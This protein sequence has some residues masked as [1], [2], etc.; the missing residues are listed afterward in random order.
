MVSSRAGVTLALFNWKKK[1]D[2]ASPATAATGER[3]GDAAPPSTAGGETGD[4]QPDPRRATKWFQHAASVA[5]TRNY[6][7]AVE[8]YVNGLKFDADNMSQHEALFEVAKRRKVN[9]GKP[10]GMFD[11]MKSMGKDAVSRFLDAERIWAKDPLNRDAMLPVLEKAAEVHN[12]IESLDLGR[13]IQWVGQMTLDANSKHK[14]PSKEAFVKAR[15]VFTAVGEYDLAVNA[16]KLALAMDESDDQLLLE[17]RDLEAERTMTQ[18][19]YGKDFKASVKDMD[20][21]RELDASDEI[22]RG[23]NAADQ[24][25]ARLR[26]EVEEAP[27]DLDKLGKLVKAME[28]RETDETDAQAIKLLRDAHERTG[29]YRFKLRAGDVTMRQ[30]NRRL[31]ALRAAFDA[32]HNN[33]EARKALADATHQ[34]RAFELEEFSERVKNYPT[35]LRLRFELGKRLYLTQKFDE[36]ISMFQEAQSDPKNKSGALFYLGACYQ[37]KGWHDEAVESF[38]RGIEAHP[39]SD[40]KLAMELRY[41]LMDALEQGA[42][43]DK[44]LD[45]AKEARD[46]G[47]QLLQTNINY[48]D[49]RQRLEKLRTLV[50][51]LGQA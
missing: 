2:G 38:R 24:L 1:S 25:I 18:A 36:A 41:H 29:Q 32:D 8:C 48:R 3:A 49:I 26:A 20:K 33:L 34:A 28:Q 6:D 5:E 37:A 22:A 23:G 51:E 40:D 17:L 31:R 7:Y 4:Y 44:N 45:R 12:K 50:E 46:V 27:D 15:D 14:R 30:W 13:F 47:S 42:R 10:E 16:C 11:R 39:L 19:Q 35:D 9:G 43:R 21:Q